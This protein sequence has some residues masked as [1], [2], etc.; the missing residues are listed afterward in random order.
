MS[1]AVE[2]SKIQKCSTL[3]TKEATELETCKKIYI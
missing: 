1:G 3:K 2:N